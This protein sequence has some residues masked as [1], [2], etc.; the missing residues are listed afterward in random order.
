MNF[1]HTKKFRHGSISLALTVII[2]AAVI[3][4]NA[5]FTALS[6]KF[7]WQIDMT[8]DQMFTLSDEA[9]DLLAG[10]DPEKKVT[11]TFCTEMDLM[12]ADGTQ[13]YP[14][15][16]AQEIEKAFGNVEVRYVDVNTN[17]SAVQEA[18]M[19]TGETINSKSI[20]LS[21]GKQHRVYT[22]QSMFTMDSSG[23]TVIGYN[24]EQRLVSGLLAITQDEA[25][26]ACFTVNHGEQDN[27]NFAKFRDAF[28]DIGYEVVLLDLRKENIPEACSLII[29]IDPQNDFSAEDDPYTDISADELKKLGRFLDARNSMMV[30]FDHGTPY[31][32]NFETFLAD[33]G[34]GIARQDE[35]ALL[36]KDRGESFDAEGLTTVGSYVKGGLG[37]TLTEKLLSK[38]NPKPV[39]FPYSAVMYNTYEADYV[40][41]GDYWKGTSN[42][43]NG[44]SRETYDV[45]TSSSRAIAEANGEALSKKELEELG[46]RLEADMPFSYMKLAR[47]SKQDNEGNMT[48]SYVL[49]CSSTDFAAAM[50]NSGYG[51]HTVLTY[52]VSVLG[53]SLVSVALDCKYFTSTEITNITATEANQYTVVLTVV[54]AAIIFIAG[55]Y[56]M[57]RRRYA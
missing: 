27:P 54:P 12:E 1:L 11:I 33:W 57:V 13:R 3:L 19:H 8:K 2:I 46:L 50:S 6:N 44:A 47:E 25:P 52:A 48:Y 39:L 22:L 21:S 29:T 31:H 36:V 34:I 14:L 42:F 16:T 10:M 51:N 17:P 49:A 40:E 20:I 35:A 24:G 32:E 45:F 9:K 56:I 28:Y 41:S 26:V 38:S 30:F 7:L 18:Q 37:A 23:S 43:A 5:I 53:R 4:V 55:I 15:R